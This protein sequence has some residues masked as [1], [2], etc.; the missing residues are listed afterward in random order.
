MA[1]GRA[2]ESLLH[3]FVN[4]IPTG[5]RRGWE[6]AGSHVRFEE[7][8]IPPRVVDE[9]LPRPT[10]GATLMYDLWVDRLTSRLTN[11]AVRGTSDVFAV[12]ALME[13]AR[14]FEQT[15]QRLVHDEG[16]RIS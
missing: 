11:F 16:G 13:K 8:P 15:V 9:R 6:M 7:V 12:E 3:V 4:Y 5:P 10:V 2:P 1:L 14:R